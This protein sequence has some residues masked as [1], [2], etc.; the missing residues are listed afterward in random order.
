MSNTPRTANRIGQV[1]RLAPCLSSDELLV[2]LALADYGDRIFPSQA[3]LAAKTRL[4]IS[5]VKRA[6]TGLRSKQVVTAKGYGKALTYMLHLAHAE[7]GTSLTQSEVVAQAER[8]GRSHR[9]RDPNTQTNYQPN[10]PPAEAGRGVAASPWE[11]IPEDAIRR[12][13]RWVP[14]GA[15]EL[16]AAQRRVTERR[17]LELGV[18]RDQLGR[19]WSRLGDRWGDTGVP[20]YDNLATTLDGIGGEVRDRLAVLAFRIGVGRVA[21]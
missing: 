9:A 5:T 13:R 18:A 20:P 2:L 17:L 15:D 1:F 12:I 10:P 19:W 8:G 4:H 16:C 3:A 6:L 11:G 21:A 7:R 14:E